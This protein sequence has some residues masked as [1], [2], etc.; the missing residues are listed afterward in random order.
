MAREFHARG[1]I[2]PAPYMSIA[3]QAQMTFPFFPAWFLVKDR[4]EN[5]NKITDLHIP[6]LMANGGK[7][8]VIPTSE[9]R[10]LYAIANQPKQFAFIP[11]A[12]HT[13]LFQ[14]EFVAL[15]LQWLARLA[16]NMG[17][18]QFTK[19]KPHHERRKKRD[20]RPGIGSE[21]AI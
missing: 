3:K 2:L 19:I 14:S 20:R 16:A 15:S 8:H 12:G 5:F 10:Q 6:I 1:I 9:G 21:I 7:D 4:Y 11:E 13:D 18:K 17:A